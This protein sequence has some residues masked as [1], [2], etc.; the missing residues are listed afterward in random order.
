MSREAHV[1]IWE[2]LGV[3]PPGR[4]AKSISN[5]WSLGSRVLGAGLL[6]MLNRQALTIHQVAFSFRPGIGTREEVR[7]LDQ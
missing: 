4:L 7:D 5:R 3:Q 6:V 1:R 2:R